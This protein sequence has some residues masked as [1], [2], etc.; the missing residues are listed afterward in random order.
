MPHGMDLPEPAVDDLLSRLPA[1]AGAPRSDSGDY[2]VPQFQG[3][4]AAWFLIIL[5]QPAESFGQGQ[6]CGFIDDVS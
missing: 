6:P 1:S 2:R 3:D 4:V 5:P